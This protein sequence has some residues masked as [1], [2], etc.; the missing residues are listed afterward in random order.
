MGV[1][2][3]HTTA[4]V[5]AAAPLSGKAATGS[6]I[7]DPRH[8]AAQARM[9]L[10]GQPSTRGAGRRLACARK[11]C[12]QDRVNRDEPIKTADAENAPDYRAVTLAAVP[13][14]W[15]GRW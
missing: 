15:R 10:S 12:L 4:G 14:R 13:C 3:C 9:F 5:I 1:Q 11:S 8:P 7:T 6:L 2:A